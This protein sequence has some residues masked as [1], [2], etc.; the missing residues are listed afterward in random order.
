MDWPAANLQ[1]VQLLKPLLRMCE[2]STN[3]GNFVCFLNV[4]QSIILKLHVLNIEA[5]K[6]KNLWRFM[7]KTLK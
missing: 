5:E 4:A 3:S 2:N 6:T 1:T 7:M